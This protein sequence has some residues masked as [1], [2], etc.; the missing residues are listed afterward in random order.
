MINGRKFSLRLYSL[1]TSAD[2]LRAYFYKDG[3][4][5]FSLDQ[6]NASSIDHYAFVTNAFVSRE[7]ATSAGPSA[8]QKA[9]QEPQRTQESDAARRLGLDLPPRTARWSYRQLMQFLGHLHGAEEEVALERAIRRLAL[10]VWV[11]ARPRLAL[12]AQ[13][14]LASLGLH[15]THEYGL[16]FELTAFDVL[17]DAHLRPWLIEINTTPSLRVESYAVDFE[18]K[19]RMLSDLLHLVDAVPDAQMSPEVTLQGLME[20][21]LNGYA[22]QC[23]RRWKLGGCRF[24]PSWAEVGQLWRSAAEQRRCGGFEP[25]SPSVDPEWQALVRE[26]TKHRSNRARGSGSA[27]RPRLD[28]LLFAWFQS[29]P[30]ACQATGETS[31]QCLIARWYSLLCDSS[32]H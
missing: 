4:A 32:D 25:L 20:L 14:S 22:T 16:T 8:A 7:R 23:R 17:L 9:Q 6:Y 27:E 1:I 19:Q 13:E 24:C 28:E 15:G 18:I 5:L 29:T 10:R 30:H 21:N 26:G 12:A 31:E 11:L 2:P 3:F